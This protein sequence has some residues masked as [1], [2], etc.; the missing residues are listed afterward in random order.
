MLSPF[1]VRDLVLRQFTGYLQFF[2][3]FDSYHP[4]DPVDNRGRDSTQ[5]IARILPASLHTISIYCKSN[6][7][8]FNVH[9]LRL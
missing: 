5:I 3:D 2:L 1:D 7:Y 4:I 6:W 8:D 9:R